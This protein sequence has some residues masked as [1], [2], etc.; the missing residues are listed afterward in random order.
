MV[1]RRGGCTHMFEWLSLNT[2]LDDFAVLQII[3]LS[4]VC[5]FMVS[6]TLEGWMA[7]AGSYLGLL[8]VG[9]ASNVGC[10]KLNIIVTANKHLDGILFTTGGII[11]GTILVVFGML[12]MSSVST[13]VGMSAQKLRSV[14][15]AKD[16]QAAMIAAVTKSRT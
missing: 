9:I 6:Q 15:N 11:V 14:S 16:A 3:A 13:R 10:R 8:G 7:M 1:Y 2:G 4:G 5:G 12:M